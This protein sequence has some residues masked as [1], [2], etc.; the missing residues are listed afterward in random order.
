MWLSHPD[1][2]DQPI[3]VD[4]ESL[5]HYARSGWV[6]TEAPIEPTTAELDALLLSTH[7][8]EPEAGP[9]EA[10]PEPP[11]EPTAVVPDEPAES[12]E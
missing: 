9:L 1:L 2:P 11:E 4:D 5:A 7:I 8:E 12:K 10:E 6:E 3:Q